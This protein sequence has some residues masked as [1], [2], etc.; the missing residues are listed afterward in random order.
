LANFFWGLVTVGTL[1]EL[2]TSLGQGGEATGLPW[3]AG[4]RYRGYSIA[5]RAMFVITEETQGGV[6]VYRFNTTTSAWVVDGPIYVIPLLADRNPVAVQLIRGVAYVSTSVNGRIY[7]FDT[8]TRTWVNGGAAV[9]AAP[10]GFALRGIALA[11]VSPSATPS[12]SSTSSPT[13]SPSA[14]MSSGASI[15]NTATPPPT[16]TSSPTASR[17]PTSSVSAT[18]SPTAST[19]ISATA[20]ATPSNSPV[21]VLPGG[22]MVVLRVATGVAATIATPVLL[23]VLVLGGSPDAQLSRTGTI[24]MPVLP[25]TVPGQMRLTVGGTDSRWG[26]LSRS[27]DGRFICIA[28]VNAAPGSAWASAAR[29]IGTLGYDG[30]V[31]VS[32]AFNSTMFS[33]GLWSASSSDGSAFYAVGSAPT[34]LTRGIWYITAGG[35]TAADN[36][37]I[38]LVRGA[39]L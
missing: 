28:G 17:S 23:D 29:T 25:P 2:P 9:Y 3:A 10:A 34:A 33:N 27:D 26:Q 35:T 31:D 39:G 14:T 38:W 22:D 24:T 5:P 32:T 16:V 19:S 15:S 21:D 4:L 7:G 1:T 20:T 12:A 8:S 30:V 18:A 11:P 37:L 36:A 6:L 13:S